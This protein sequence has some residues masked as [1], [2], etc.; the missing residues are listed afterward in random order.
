MS[1][2]LTPTSPQV[3]QTYALLQIAA[4]SFL[5]VDRDEPA[6][7]PGDAPGLTPTIKM[8][9]DGNL[10]SS[11]MT[12]ATDL[13]VLPDQTQAKQFIDAWEVVSYQANTSTGFSAT[14]FRCKA[15]NETSAGMSVGQ[16][17]V[18]FRSTE[19]VED[20]V[21]DN[22]ATNELEIKETG[23]AL[24]Q[25]ADMRTWWNSLPANVLSGKVDVTGYSLGGHLAATFNQLYPERV[26]R[27]YTFNGAGI[28]EVL[29]G[30]N[31]LHGVL[32]TFSKLRA[33][34]SADMFLDANVRSLY[35]R[36]KAALAEPDMAAVASAR[37]EIN[38]LRQALK[39]TPG[40]NGAAFELNLLDQAV[41]RVRKVLG[42]VAYLTKVTPTNGL[43][44]AQIAGARNIAAL[45]LDYQ[46]AVLRTKPQLRPVNTSL[47]ASLWEE[48][49][50][51]AK[52]QLGIDSRN[53]IGDGKGYDVYGAPWPS[54][55]ANSQRHYGTPVPVFIEDQPLARGSVL[56]TGLITRLRSGEVRTLLPGYDVNDFGD[57]HSIVLIEDSLRVQS[58][59]ANLDPTATL[60]KLS[61]LMQVASNSTSDTPILTSGQ[62][63]AA[64][65]A[66]EAFLD[67]GR[68]V[69]LGPG[70][71]PTLNKANRDKALTGGTWADDKVLRPLLEGGVVQFANATAGLKGML[72]IQ[73]SSSSMDV[74]QDFG[75]F[76]SIYALSILH[77]MGADAAGHSALTEKLKSQWGTIYADWN[78]DRQRVSNPD[79]YVLASFTDSWLRSRSA[80]LGELLRRNSTKTPD[81]S[82]TPADSS[83]GQAITYIDRTQGRTFNVGSTLPG[84]DR[85]QVVFGSTSNETLSGGARG[86][87]LY[88][89]DGND[90]L[91]G[92]KGEDWLEGNNGDDQIDGAEDN[93]TL[94]GGAGNDKLL[95]ASGRDSLVGGD[96]KDTLNGGADSDFLAGGKGDDVY[97]FDAGWGS[98]TIRDVVGKDSLDVSGFGAAL[99]VGKRIS[100]SS[101][102]YQSANR[103]VVYT[104]EPLTGPD[105]SS[106]LIVSFAGRKDTIRIEGWTPAH[107][108]GI[109]LEDPDPP[110]ATNDTVLG[111]APNGSLQVKYDS[112]TDVWSLTPGGAG[113]GD[114]LI[115]GR[116]ADSLAGLGGADALIGNGGADVLDGGAGDDLIFGN[117]EDTIIGGDGND[118]IL[119]GEGT[120]STSL[121]FPDL[122]PGAVVTR[123]GL[124]WRTYQLSGAAGPALLP[125]ESG[126]REYLAMNGVSIERSI[127]PTLPHLSHGLTVDAGVGNDL[128]VGGWNDDVLFGGDGNDKLTGR[129]GADLID[130]GEG[131]DFLAGDGPSVQGVFGTTVKTDH[132]DDTLNGGGG[133]DV[134]WANGGDDLLS[135][136]DGNDSLW[137]D[138]DYADWTDPANHGKDQLS[139]GDGADQLIGGGN[140]DVLLGGTGDDRIWADG[141]TTVLLDGRFHGRDLVDAG[142]GDDYA[143]GGGSDDTLRG[144]A[145][146][147]TL[148][149]DGPTDK[150]DVSFSG[151][152]VIDGGGGDD[153]LIG[154]GGSDTLVGGEGDDS[155][156][157]D[158]ASNDSI[159]ASAEGDDSIDGGNGNDVID[160]GG[161]QDSVLGGEG[162]DVIHGGTGN[163]QLDGGAGDDRIEAGDGDDL[164]VGG[165]GTDQLIGGAGNDT[166]VFAGGDL[167]LSATGAAESIEDEQGSNALI[168][169]GVDTSYLQVGTYSDG[170]VFIYPS[171]GEALGLTAA[172]AAAISSITING[173]VYSLA[174]LVGEFSRTPL[175][176]D[177]PTSTFA[178][179]GG[180]QDDQI[181]VARSSAQIRGGNGNDIITATGSGYTF[182][183]GLGDGVD[184]VSVRSASARPADDGSN[185]RKAQWARNEQAYEGTKPASVASEANVLVFGAGIAPSDV[186][187]Q[188]S[189]GSLIV[190]IGALEESSISFDNFDGAKALSSFTISE[191]RFAD[192]TVLSHADL[193]ARGFDILGTDA[194]ESVTGTSVNDRLDGGLGDDTLIGG[195]GSDAYLFER[196]SGHKVVVESDVVN[197]DVD[198]V[199]IGEGLTPDD[200]SI[201]RSGNGLLIRILSTD[202]S[203]FVTNHFAGQAVEGLV[204]AD[205]TQWDAAGLAAHT[206]TGL[207]DSND[208]YIGTD[209]AET[210][211]G[212]KGNDTISGAG[213]DDTISGG[214]GNDVINGGN[215]SDLID[216]GAG[217]DYF[218]SSQG[219]DTYIFGRG[220]GADVL[221]VALQPG[222]ASK[223]RL[224]PGI[225]EA[226]LQF[227]AG[228]FGRDITITILGTTDSFT[229][230]EFFTRAPTAAYVAQMS[231]EFAD[232]T[233]WSGAQLVQKVYGGTPGNDYLIANNT[234][235][236]VSG[237]AGNDTLHG[238]LGDDTLNGGDGQD[239]L[240]GG[241]GNDTFINGEVMEGGAGNDTYVVDAWPVGSAV[242]TIRDS[243]GA[244]TL[245]LPV[246]ATSA[247]VSV[248]N[249]G[250]YGLRLAF[251]R[252]DGSRATILVEGYFSG[253]PGYSIEQIKFRDGTAWTLA[254]VV[255]RAE[256]SNTTDGPDT[257][258]YGFGWDETINAKGGNDVVN[259]LAGNDMLD[260]GAGNDTLY[261]DYGND[262]VLGGTG[263]DLLYGDDSL[264]TAAGNDQLDGGAGSDTLN[265]GLGDD[266]YFFGRLSDSDIVNEAGGTD[267]IVLDAGITRANVTLY[268][269][270][271]DLVVVIDGGRTQLRVTGHFS[272]GASTQKV[273]SIVF[274]DGA[275]WDAAYIASNAS[276]SA[277]ANTFT[278][279]AGNDSF[280]V[281][282][283]A[284]IVVEGENQ[285][286]DTVTS[287]T[288]YRLPA[289]VENL[290]LTGILNTWGYGNSLTNLI[291]GNAGD[292]KFK[293]E[294]GADTLKGGAGNDFYDITIGV[295]AKDGRAST[296]TVI[297]NP[298]EG[299]D[300]VKVNNYDYTLPAN[301]ENMIAVTTELE[302]R[303]SSGT[304]IPRR[305]IGNALNNVID[306]SSES[307][308]ANRLDGGLGADTLIGG[309][310][311]NIYVVDNALDVLIEAPNNNSIDTVETSV[312]WTLAD[313]FENL[314]LVGSAAIAG[315]GNASNNVL[316]GSANAAANVLTG[317]MGD[318]TYVLGA[319]DTAVEQSGG[320]NDTVQLTTGIQ[321]IYRLADYANIEGLYL[322]FNMGASTLLGGFGD[323][324]LTGNGRGNSLDGG[325]GND[326]LADQPSKSQVGSPFLEDLNDTLM[327]G[328]GAD[329]LISRAGSDWLEGGRGNDTIEVNDYASL[330]GFKSTGIV[331]FKNGDGADLV[332]GTRAINI[333]VGGWTITDLAVKA[334]GT[335]YVLS[336]GDGSDKLTVENSSRGI[337]I[338]FD[339][340]VVL[341]ASGLAS[342]SA[343][344]G[345]GPG[346]A[347]ADFLLGTNAADTLYGIAGDDTI[348][349]GV[350]DDIIDGGDGLN[351]LYGG[352][353]NDT[354]TGGADAD[355]VT[356]GAGND[357]IDV[358][359]AANSGFNQA[360]GGLGNDTLLGG[361]DID[362]LSGDDGADEIH[363][364]LGN[365]SLSGG[366]GDDKLYGE[367]GND[368][369]TGGDGN[370]SLVGAT[371]GYGEA[372]NDTVIGTSA[373]DTLDGG[374]GS[375]ALSGLAGNDTLRGGNGADTLEGGAGNDL[376]NGE[377]GNDVYRFARGDG[378][379]TITNTF[380]DGSADDLLFAAGIAPADILVAR[381]GSAD[382]R[383]SING[384]SDSVLITGFMNA[385]APLARVIFAD[386]TT[387]DRAFLLDQ[388]L[389][390]RGTSGADSLTGGTSND[391]LLGLEGNDT[392]VG[393]AGAD[394]LDGGAGIDRLVGGTGN[395]VYIV[396][397]ATDVIVENA[398]EGDLDWVRSSA[399]TFT[400]PSNVEHLELIGTA[401]ISGTG[402]SL[403]NQI[404][405]N[406]GNNSLSGG[407]GA[408]FM[409]GGDGNDTLN[410]GTGFDYMEGG[411]GD[412]TYFVDATP[413]FDA[414]GNLTSGDNVWE[415]DGGGIDT[416]SAGVNYT[417]PQAVENLI[418]TGTG[419]FSGTGNGLANSITGNS[420]ANLLTGGDGDDTLN[421]GA[422]IDTLAG[423]N[424]NDSYVVDVSTDVITEAADAGIDSVTSTASYSLSANVEN[425]TL[426]GSSSINA[427]GNGLAN[428]LTG[429]SGINR[430]DG[431]AGA[432]TMIGGA[433][434]DTYVV[435]SVGD[436]ITELAGGGTDTVESNITYVLGAELENLTLVGSGAI[437]GTGN[438][439]ANVLTGNASANRLDGGAGIDTM[440]GGA[441]NDTYVVDNSADVVTEAASGGTDTV[442]AS[443]T[444]ALSAEVESL[445][446]TGTAAINATGNGVANTLRGNAADNVLD[447]GGGA[448][449]MI[450]GAGNDTYVVDATTDVVT[451]A[452]GEGIDT[453]RTTV[454]LPTLVANVEN[455]TLLGTTGLSAT[456]NALA[457]VLTGNSGANRLDGGDGDDTLDGGAGIDT[458]LGG[459][460]N[461]VF[462]VDSTS[463]VVTEASGQGVDTIRTTVT[464]PSLVANVENLTLLG[465][466]NLN[467]TGN[468]LPNVLT[469]NSGA[470][471]LDGGDG[472]DTL[473]GGMGIDTMLGGL[474]ND[475]F[476]VDSASDVV[477]EGSGQGTDTIMTSVTLTTLAANVENLTLIGTGNIDGTG[478]S[479]DNLMT[480]NVG[481]NLLTGAAGNDTLD[482]KAGNDTLNG[483]AG[484]DIYLFGIGYGADVIVDSDATAGVKDVVK[485]GAGIAQADIRFTQSGNSLVATIK[486]TSESLTIQDW[487]LSA[488]NR[489][490]EF[491][492]VDGTVLTNVQAQ[493]LVGAMAAFNPVGAGIAMVDDS[494]QHRSRAVGLAVSATA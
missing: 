75:A 340:G 293:S 444:Y 119:D 300:T 333:S 429:N 457:N 468:A 63:K 449:T 343:S 58:V 228:P 229:V 282:H 112:L 375:D 148:W 80:M 27:Y 362:Y 42:S 192:G 103:T 34:G 260:G 46:L 48:A 284:D 159:A 120:L 39:G 99:P 456:G 180:N 249:A 259:A 393:G 162:N 133:D 329:S 224:R 195:T 420:G 234:G 361:S 78:D 106:T 181:A 481:N 65:D 92:A 335:G 255:A 96:G 45:G 68:F 156:A 414:N 348:Y 151:A 357:L 346:T 30:Y 167:L 165:A 403:D 5:N 51:W 14:L 111:D 29:G 146:K 440:I 450:G 391:K 334:Q 349:G 353:G 100:G 210:I 250:D 200:L 222:W 402:N 93:D 306:S 491:R 484:A 370:D 62:G 421:G 191:Y 489:V 218:T 31:Q 382:L 102:V 316:D 208:V 130:G 462:I 458:M 303:D 11:R 50:S 56:L 137:G 114:V 164:V 275:V 388:L 308:A 342:L 15:I 492:F 301:V 24:G 69:F 135:G 169:N 435:D 268:N 23:W 115:G 494:G 254:D 413:V 321:G 482:G 207:T 1:V 28:G 141:G 211:D 298:N 399:A 89:G 314:K 12:Y 320:G 411:L 220:D 479:G 270:S 341:D 217:D 445:T 488:N 307:F 109:T 273:E 233:T 304:A 416:V 358:K 338:S 404:V 88:G 327:G 401:N 368:S 221:D 198:R 155:I 466:G 21:R 398:G 179:Y 243:G 16:Y 339:D 460:G 387:W 170:S 168:L 60:G 454:T 215:G 332:K 22:V 235:W 281:D 223:I 219:T 231:L 83:P 464:L 283:T 13:G 9:T 66:V 356:G 430:L 161:G 311:N 471:R 287:S 331:R 390:I 330:T 10:H 125:W 128:V 386:G 197:G 18:S 436:V 317:G 91:S 36:M 451:E 302:N 132:G 204:F 184:K 397:E 360:S 113:S 232:G 423:G 277:V 427:T 432:D 380:A 188:Y 292:N 263:D 37:T 408:D 213:G 364:G 418:L 101:N 145:G 246:G 478:S 272:Q 252:P 374:D 87:S 237:G 352:D 142:E 405:G 410:G 424:G 189:D 32:D 33:S 305:L 185:L 74:R 216:G 345:R 473:D 385:G 467:A 437:N 369:L 359:G 407:G 426:T 124:T 240:N 55:V 453:I 173:E 365:D 239:S 428:V 76:A 296:V 389:T 439:I 406:S 47:P 150:L 172:T 110:A 82:S 166:Y 214:D 64:G 175:T 480:G 422:G 322:G 105:G 186:W 118:F 177:T 486:S 25:I 367:G 238:G 94:L 433:G 3:L 452:F 247:N 257:F 465:T 84:R 131:N 336:F 40:E 315:T 157:G 394:T 279:T 203:L 363:G 236:S 328:D 70:T 351:Q 313:Q 176:L 90:S 71:E 469:G 455:L 493:A 17:V 476:Y 326:F 290:T 81:D 267:R 8:L 79:N 265:G 366:A 258:I 44:P 438:G 325:A 225:S 463:D 310:A 309:A 459:L 49:K 160:A 226:D 38:N 372:G 350:G 280:V 347:G 245:L 278:G 190:H 400:L 354:I 431:G 256:V 319:G 193:L 127:D 378:A 98:D 73:L 253:W 355:S 241:G 442:E 97:V 297:E 59:Y 266:T 379:D 136:G 447:G 485:F 123:Q 201:S 477:T 286:I 6:K 61:G 95:G 182:G 77:F 434:N 318:D 129:E 20:H 409:L 415:S 371:S 212:R 147:D 475:V 187:L 446:L 67:A 52:S 242:T 291:V 202:D 138:D 154:G 425:L 289:N 35:L 392:L 134:I 19:F 337:R 54:A 121:V 7:T 487:Y 344:G 53:Q 57:T 143:E 86:D 43:P 441:G 41:T 261:G 174:E 470:N 196:G 324:S 117:Q 417:L 271:D 2:G 227:S 72:K 178:V 448:D 262:T 244:D 276:G 152:D 299:I 144:G 194:S 108:F 461:D 383:L 149:G 312:N 269:D 163:D 377:A 419:N 85:A 140:D 116:N 376:L 443:V 483:G 107:N 381:S 474:G 294:L 209:G 158:A 122:P 295:Y 395:D 274:A 264:A 206:T 230:K 4:E 183:Y 472:D 26:N 288:S 490:E 248:V 384:T 171:E 139:G 285:G 104:L 205:G 323:D 126:T 396:D 373:N 199:Y 153:L 251:K 412:D